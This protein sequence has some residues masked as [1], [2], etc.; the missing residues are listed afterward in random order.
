MDRKITVFLF[1]ILFSLLNNNLFGIQIHDNK[2]S[3]DN[4]KAVS[5]SFPIFADLVY[6]YR[7]A[8]LNN[9]TPIELEYNERV[10]RYIDVYTIE[11]RKH[12]AEIIGLSKLYFPLFEEKLDKYNLPFELKYLAIVESALNPKAISSSDAVGLWQFKLNTGRMFNL[13]VNSYIDERCDP[14]LSTEAACSYLQYL[15]RIFGDW[16]LALAAYNGGPG[17]V[18]KAI[19]RSGGKTNFWEILPYLPEQTKNYVPAFIAVNYVMNYHNEH[20]I[21]SIPSK[22][23][24][25]DIDSLQITQSVSFKRISDVLDIPI[26]TLEFLNP[27]YKQNYIPKLKRDAIVILPTEKILPFLRNEEMIFDK[28]ISKKEFVDINDIG[29]TKNKLEITHNVKK[30]EYFHKIAI[31]YNCTIED[32]RIWNNLIN[33]DLSVGQKLVIWVDKNIAEKIAKEKNIPKQQ[34]DINSRYIYYIVKNGDTIWSIAE[35]FNCESIEELKE[36]NSIINETDI[37]TGE[38]LKIYLNN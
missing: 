33:N 18:K 20:T 35:K 19:E 30:G 36:V 3:N 7:I 11:R 8:E 32:I 12:L 23:I 9:L 34:R 25:I 26:A 4:K 13:K 24:N 38:K 2:P 1:V 27:I 29:L 10:R 21:G 16:Q 17:E 37:K 14:Y 15:H 5:D 6:E 28:N 31:K 22:Y